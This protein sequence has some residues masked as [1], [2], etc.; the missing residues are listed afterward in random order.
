V[1]GWKKARLFAVIM[2]FAESWGGDTPNAVFVGDSNGSIERIALPRVCRGS[3]TKK[4][5]RGIPRDAPFETHV[6]AI[7]RLCF[8]KY[9]ENGDVRTYLVSSS[10]DKTVKVQLLENP[11]K[12]NLV[13]TL[14]SHDSSDVRGLLCGHNHFHCCYSN[15]QMVKLRV[16]GGVG[17]A[18]LVMSYHDVRL[19][20]AGGC[21][22]VS[23]SVCRLY[24]PLEYDCFDQ[25]LHVGRA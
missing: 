18:R 4:V 22:Q 7:R 14:Q 5:A 16:Q 15:V 8:L 19:G 3:A 9:D 23:I 13:Y 24:S 21:P 10:S 20:Q 2:P 12:T 25:L 11:S 1:E 6:G 17:R